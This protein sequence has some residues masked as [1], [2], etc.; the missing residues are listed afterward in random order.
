[1]WRLESRA[2]GVR[3]FECFSSLNGQRFYSA[4]GLRPVRQIEVSLSPDAAIPGV[5]MERSI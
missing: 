3:R 2:A 5:L 4:L 1:M